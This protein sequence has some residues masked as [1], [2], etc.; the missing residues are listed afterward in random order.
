MQTDSFLAFI[1]SL[2]L[3]IRSIFCPSSR[4]SCKMYID[5]SIS[6][7]SVSFGGT[8]SFATVGGMTGVSSPRQMQK[9][10]IDKISKYVNF[11][12]DALKRVKPVLFTLLLQSLECV[13][14]VLN[15]NFHWTMVT[16]HYLGMDT[17]A[18]KSLHKPVGHKEVVDAPPCVL[19]SCLKA[20]APP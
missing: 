1:L 2:P 17:C 14:L 16:S 8:A 10:R 15:H 18:F 7:F 13:F 6:A 9:G 3:R 19:S 12:I 20:V 5:V 4:L 11:F